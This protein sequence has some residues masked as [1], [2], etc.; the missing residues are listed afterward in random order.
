MNK[1]AG[2]TKFF[3]TFHRWALFF[4]ALLLL[5]GMPSTALLAE[6]ARAIQLA[7]D[8]PTK[9]TDGSDLTDLAGYRLYR[10]SASEDAE[11]PERVFYALIPAPITTY[12]DA[13]VEDGLKYSYS[14]TA[15]NASGVE[16]GHSNVANTVAVSPRRDRDGDGVPNGTDNC[17]LVANPDQTDSDGD[18]TG[19]ACESNP[20]PGSDDDGD[21]VPND[22]DNCKG[23][24]N[25]DQADSNNNGIGDVC[26]QRALRAACSTSDSALVSS[27]AV[28]NNSKAALIDVQ[29]L[30]AAGVDISASAKV[31]FGDFNAIEAGSQDFGDLEIAQVLPGENALKHWQIASE[32]AVQEIDF[33]AVKAEPLSCYADGDLNL[34]PAVWTK[35]GFS[36]RR[37]TDGQ[38]FSIKFNGLGLVRKVFC[39]DLTQDGL[40]ELLVLHDKA[41]RG[42]KGRGRAV[43]TASM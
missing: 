8:A 17:P 43:M 38:E 13:G 39:A 10:A 40:D 20:L 34:D 28:Y 23:I 35:S 4:G 5:S 26:E 14:V 30:S 22:T 16:S 6:G 7:W 31:L 12:V 18:G 2:F 15:I 19:D 29:S 24:V 11:L 25:P 33:G 36:A 42:V 41:P 21:G 1:V 3:A 9:N 27:I 32:S 37:S